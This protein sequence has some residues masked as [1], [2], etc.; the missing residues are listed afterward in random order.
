MRDERQKLK[1]A[2][3][4]QSPADIDSDIPI[5]PKRKPKYEHEKSEAAPVRDGFSTHTN[6]EEATADRNNVGGKFLGVGTCGK[7]RTS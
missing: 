2:D 5:K 6:T 3:T 7:F 1:F 4:P